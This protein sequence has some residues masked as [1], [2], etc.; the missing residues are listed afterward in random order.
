[1]IDY[2]RLRKNNNS[3]S[4]TI[5]RVYAVTAACFLS[6]SCWR[7]LCILWRKT[8]GDATDSRRLSSIIP[9]ATKRLCQQSIATAGTS[10]LGAASLFCLQTLHF[11]MLLAMLK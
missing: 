10:V 8:A 5:L 11:C 2:T 4:N 7:T 1:M 6:L 3:R 9:K